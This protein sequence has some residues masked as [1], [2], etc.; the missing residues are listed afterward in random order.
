MYSL[1]IFILGV[2]GAIIYAIANRKELFN[3]KIVKRKYGPDDIITNPGPALIKSIILL[4]VMVLISIIQPYS[5]EKVDAGYQGVLVNL[6]GSDRGVSDVQMKSGWVT[7]NS[8]FEE[9]YEFPTFQ[10]HVMYEELPVILKGGFEAS[11][12]PTFNYNLKPDMITNMF[13]ELRLGIKQI[14]Q[15]WLLTAITSSIN[16]V[17]N[18]WK[19]EEIFENREK[20]ES[21]IIDECNSRVDKWFIMSQLRTN[22]AP[23]LALKQAIEDKTRASQEAE[24]EEQKALVAIAQ[25]KRMVEQAKADS[26]KRVIDASSKAEAMRIK[27]LGEADAYK[28]KNRELTPLLIQQ[29]YLERWSGDYGTGNVFGEGA[30]L[31]KNVGR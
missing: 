5:L 27:A 3:K 6:V 24:A 16:D 19:V 29:Q 13:S 17:S 7:Y 1:I 20:F 26:A 8:W 31:Y 15:G 11:I 21:E 14:E 23:P 30:I 10:Q 4:F 18:R 25:G 9:L 12:R 22:I 2:L 28:L